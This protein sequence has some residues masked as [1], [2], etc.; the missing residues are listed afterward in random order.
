MQTKVNRLLLIGTTMALLGGLAKAEVSFEK[1][2]QPVLASACLSCHGEK[3]PKGELQLHTHAGLL[4]G[5]EYG[6]VVVPGKPE[7]STLYTTTILPP[8]DDDIMPPKGEP[9][10]SDQ[11]DV[12]KEWIAAGAKWPEGLV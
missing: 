9:L 10:T 3:K 2:V 11:A 7:K 12:L 8:D 5:S 1:Q 6:K 4:E